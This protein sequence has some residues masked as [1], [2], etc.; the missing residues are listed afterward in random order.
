LILAPHPDDESLGCGGFIATCCALGHPPVIAVL[1][2][3]AGSHPDLDDTVRAFLRTQRA[4][5]VRD[6]A[7][8]LGLPP[9]NLELFDLPDG[10]LTNLIDP[11][12]DALT[13]LARRQRCDL[14]LAPSWLDRHADHQAAATIAARVAAEINA[15]CL[16]YLTWAWTTPPDAELPETAARGWR[17]NIAPYLPAKRRAIVAHES[18]YFGLPDDPWQSC[19]P[20]DL[21]AAAHREY[22]VLLA[23]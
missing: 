23:P 19:L 7:A 8:H 5:E 2:D 6:A 13:D 15:P 20:A 3:G 16:S 21:L 9:E 22:E 12:A 17:L 18:Q 1:T 11:C 4:Q 14:V 10:Q